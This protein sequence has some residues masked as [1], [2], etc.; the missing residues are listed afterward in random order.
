[1]PDTVVPQHSR[2]AQKGTTIISFNSSGAKNDRILHVNT[3]EKFSC[4]FL[5]TKIKSRDVQIFRL[6]SAPYAFIIVQ[7]PTQMNPRPATHERYL[8]FIDCARN[9]PTRTA[10]ADAVIR[11]QADPRNTVSLLF[12]DPDAYRNVAI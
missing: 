10:I 4:S 8:K 7:M 1:M 9:E 2:Q 5:Q 11:A 6:L 12:V 3:K